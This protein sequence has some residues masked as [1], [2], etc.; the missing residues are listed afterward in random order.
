MSGGD[1]N[2]GWPTFTLFVGGNNN[3]VTHPSNCNS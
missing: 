1:E 3:T 2:Q